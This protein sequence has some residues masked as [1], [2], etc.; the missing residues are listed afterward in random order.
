MNLQPNGYNTF[1]RK[2]M[3]R[4]NPSLNLN[5][6]AAIPSKVSPTVS[7]Q[8]SKTI[9]PKIQN[10]TEKGDAG[11]IGKGKTELTKV[12]M[13]SSVS[14]PIAR[15]PRSAPSLDIVQKSDISENELQPLDFKTNTET[16]SLPGTPAAQAVPSLDSIEPEPV[17]EALLKDPQ[18]K[19]LCLSL[20]VGQ[21]P[22]TLI[23]P[24]QKGQLIIG[25]LQNSLNDL[26][27]LKIKNAEKKGEKFHIQQSGLDVAVRALENAERSLKTI[28][29]FKEPVFGR[30]RRQRSMESYSQNQKTTDAVIRILSTAMEKFDKLGNNPIPN[31][32]KN[33][34]FFSSSSPSTTTSTTS[35]RRTTATTLSGGTPVAPYNASAPRAKTATSATSFGNRN[36]KGRFVS[37]VQ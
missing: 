10:V 24:I 32:M 30:A 12:S 31:I 37:V 35:S 20:G 4:S 6:S 21:N 5:K 28:K 14:T 18:L 27:K 3:S 7:R 2:M 16:K 15:K 36:G 22:N 34:P 11:L 23:G 19:A 1:H 25:T 33:I 8:S 13:T 29:D 9:L 17:C 26:I